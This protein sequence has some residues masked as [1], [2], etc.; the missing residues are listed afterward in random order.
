M[1]SHNIKDPERNRIYHFDAKMKKVFGEPIH[2]INK[3]KSETDLGYSFFNIQS[4]L[5][6][7]FISEKKT[8]A[9]KTK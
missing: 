7:H 4:Y 1:D 3:K 6:P 2:P 9:P 5:K 8:D